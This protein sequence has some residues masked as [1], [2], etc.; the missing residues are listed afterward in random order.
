[1]MKK[2]KRTMNKMMKK[3]EKNGIEMMM[4]P[5]IQKLKEIEIMRMM[6]MVIKTGRTDFDDMK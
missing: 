5:V 4:N 2:M 3:I 6:R 1:M